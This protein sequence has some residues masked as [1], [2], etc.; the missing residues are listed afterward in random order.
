MD[1]EFFEHKA[2]QGI[3]GF[4][5]TMEEAFENGAIALFE[6]MCD[7]SKV[8]PKKRVAIHVSAASLETLF[9]E[10]LNAL[11]AESDVEGMLFSRFKVEIKKE[12]DKYTL[13]GSAAGEELDGDKHYVKTEAKAA[14]YSGLKSG[15]KDGKKFFQCVIDV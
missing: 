5:N 13:T 2:D 15:E 8:E 10:W 1:Y 6:I 12:G 9:V 4:G 7:T 3:R 14:T 11:L